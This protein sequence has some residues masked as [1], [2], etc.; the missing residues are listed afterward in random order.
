MQTLHSQIIGSGYPLLILHGFLGMSDNWKTLALAYEKEGFQ[1]HLI[2]QRN[3][4]RSF[5]SDIFNYEA[6]SDD[7]KL[8]IETH[9]LKKIA[10]IGHSMG[11]KT[12]MLFATKY[13][14][15]V[16]HLLVADIAPKLYPAHHHSIIDALNAMDFNIIKSRGDAEKTLSKF[17]KEKPTRLFLLKNLYWE[18]P[19]KLGLRINLPVLSKS[20]DEIGSPLPSGAIFKGKTLFLKGEYSEYIN[21]SDIPLIHTHFPNAQIITISKS[22][23]WLHAEN[24]MA[25]FKYSSSFLK[26]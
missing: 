21:A 1:V 5:H 23:H 4:G 25:F 19:N 2:D 13:P 24:P 9:H 22:G 6:M 15:K 11:G 18:T 17:I 26:S 16:S 7:L 14:E 12:A 8:Y 3:H 10:I 20:M